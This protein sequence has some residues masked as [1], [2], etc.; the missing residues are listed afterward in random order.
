MQTKSSKVTSL[1]SV[2]AEDWFTV[3]QVVSESNALNLGVFEV[4]ED[5]FKILKATECKCPRCWKYRS[6]SEEVLCQRCEEALNG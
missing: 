1:N 5:S 6:K 2:D 4:G 3:S